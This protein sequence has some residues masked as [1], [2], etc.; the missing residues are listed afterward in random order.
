MKWSIEV[1]PPLLERA[2]AREPEALAKLIEALTSPVYNL[3]VR[4]LGQPSDAEDATQEALLRMIRGLPS[5]RGEAAFSTWAYR[6]A[7]RSFLSTKRRRME[8]MRI[9]HGVEALE[10]GLE[11]HATHGAYDG[12]DAALLAEEVKLSCTTALLACLSRPLRM[13]YIVGEILG[14]P[15]PEAAA[16]LEVSPALFR[17]RLSLAR[18][19]VRAFLEPRCEHVDAENSCACPK[20]V[21]Y[22]IEVGWVVPG[23]LRFAKAERT[24]AMK[25]LEGTF[26]RAAALYASHPEY[27]A[28][29]ALRASLR[30]ALGSVDTMSGGSDD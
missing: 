21:A 22:D 4:F 9:E 24:A 29:G 25:S 2:A 16:V 28:P 18:Q 12:A 17:K 15:G 30:D 8:H 26:D 11:H 20:Q 7:V 1:P 19:K 10:R 6:V 3:A 5:F 13:A 27:E 23:D 14:M